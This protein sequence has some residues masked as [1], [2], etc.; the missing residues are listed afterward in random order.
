MALLLQ[1]GTPSIACT[2]L[3]DK[4]NSYNSL[5]LEERKRSELLKNPPLLISPVIFPF[6][7]YFHHHI[8]YNSSLGSSLLDLK[9]FE[10]KFAMLFKLDFAETFI[11][12][13]LSLEE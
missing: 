1:Q 2:H 3:N 9:C 8:F 6:S 12:L 5:L 13:A 11:G 7:V 10:M 4:M